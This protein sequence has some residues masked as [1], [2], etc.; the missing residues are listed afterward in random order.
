M[1]LQVHYKWELPLGE[2]T[3]FWNPVRPSIRDFYF[4]SIM[5]GRLAFR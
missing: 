1:T 5:T 2:P 4:P 3:R